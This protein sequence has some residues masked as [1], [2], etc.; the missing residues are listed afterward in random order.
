MCL[1]VGVSK[2]PGDGHAMV[3]ILDEVQLADPV[4]VDRRHRLAAA[5]RRRDSLPAPAH[6]RRGGAELAV[7][8][9]VAACHRTD[10]A[11]QSDLVNADVALAA[12]AQRGDH[13]L[14]R[15]HLRYVGRLEPYVQRHSY[16][17]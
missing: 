17:L 1:D 8:L 16:T 15:Q 13:L 4:H 3:A 10:D 2:R 14:E 7:E 5:T 9:V 11:V 6:A 12:T